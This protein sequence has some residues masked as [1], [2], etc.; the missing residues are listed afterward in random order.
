MVRSIKTALSAVLS[1]LRLTDE[2]LVTA[3]TLVE[4]VLNSKKLTPVSEDPSDPEC[5]TPNHLL[6]VREN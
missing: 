4:N 2:I 5:L 3:L 1:K 6:I